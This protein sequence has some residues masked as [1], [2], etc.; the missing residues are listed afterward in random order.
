MIW[1]AFGK[2]LSW[3][4]ARYSGIASIKYPI[5]LHSDLQ[6]K[7]HQLPKHIQITHDK[8]SSSSSLLTTV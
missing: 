4:E 3:P 1:E 7:S 8:K 2:R 6:R 5:V